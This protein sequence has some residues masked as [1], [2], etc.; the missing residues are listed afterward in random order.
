MF[1]NSKQQALTELLEVLSKG[2]DLLA[3]ENIDR[4]LYEAFEK[5]TNSTI[6]MVYEAYNL[7]HVSYFQN[8]PNYYLNQMNPIDHTY[9]SMG[10]SA[11]SV[12]TS[13][14]YRKKLKKLLQKLI[15]VAKSIAY[16]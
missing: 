14:E 12:I 11:A 4:Y 15:Y 5:Y 9:I 7:R 1:N 3:K 8:Q 16:E 6:K 10:H 2:V 13:D